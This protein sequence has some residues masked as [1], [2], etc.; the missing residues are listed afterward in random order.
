[1]V[2]YI[3]VLFGDGRSMGR[4]GTRRES[5]GKSM[6]KL[7]CLMLAITLM[8]SFA[9]PAMA[10]SDTDTQY[11]TLTITKF[12]MDRVPLKGIP[13]DGQKITD[14]SLDELD[15]LQGIKFTIVQVKPAANQE[16]AQ[17]D[18]SA[19]YC[20]DDGLYY[21]VIGP[22]ITRTTDADGIA[23]FS[24]TGEEGALPS[25]GL[26]LGVYYV[27]EQPSTKVADP[28]APFFV[29]IP[30]TI[31]DYETGE[32]IVLY[33]VFAYP[34]N[35]DIGI[36]K[37]IEAGYAWNQ[38]G[39]TDVG[40]F[41]MI[42]RDR[43]T[44][45]GMGVAHDQLIHY[46]ITVDIP[47]D[48]ASAKA[49]KVTDEYT[50]GLEFSPGRSWPAVY[51][52][53]LAE[54]ADWVY[55]L[56]Y[57]TVIHEDLQ[58]VSHECSGYWSREC[59]DE[60]FIN[61]TGFTKDG[62]KFTIVFSEAGLGELSKYR[63]ISTSISF[64]VTE[65]ASLTSPIPNNARLEYTNR[66]GTE[67]VR[68]SEVDAYSG[69]IKI[70]K[71]D[72]V[73]TGLGLKGAKFALLP[74]FSDDYAKDL[75]SFMPRF[76]SRY[77]FDYSYM[78]VEFPEDFEWETFDY[79]LYATSDENGIVEFKGI[80][81]GSIVNGVYSPT[82]TDYWLVEVESP[83]GYRLPAKPSVVTISSTSWTTTNEVPIKVANV[84][85]FNFPLTGGTGTTLFAVAAVVLAVG[86]YAL[87]RASRKEGEHTV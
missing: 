46:R 10:G 32:D 16:A 38:F 12:L 21:E 9:L 2:Q 62:G 66:Y 58:G 65:N 22:A 55:L 1:M 29:S 61:E 74:K 77:L 51:G 13:H 18:Q 54:G 17:A 82:P 3:D 26:P 36:T 79:S 25:G 24:H 78:Y 86:A 57:Y 52:I 50:R 49:F 83:D 63:A 23:Y 87:N 72:S 11:G 68:E 5:K 40:E 80:P 44:G 7:V 47:T 85:G 8:L 84:K 14:G 56:D 4:V 81:Y 42:H 33:N 19:I 34:K 6:R 71:H 27:V 53:P 73:I 70:F 75:K 67:V 31:E 43:H 45:M 15:L 39:Y 69:G 48:I 60:D 37:R 59:G 28:A 30:T 76:G 64:R 20:K 35:E 41:D